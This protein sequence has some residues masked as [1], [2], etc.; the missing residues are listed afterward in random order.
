VRFLLVLLALLAGL[1]A[2]AEAP[3]SLTGDIRYQL[4]FHSQFLPNDRDIVV[5]LPPGYD[6]HPKRRYPV[7][8]M[9]DGQNLFD[10]A[11]SFI[12]GQ[13]WRADETAEALI[14]SG[15]IRPLI[16][17]GIYNGGDS[18]IDD[19]TQIADSDIKAGGKAELYG[20]LIVEELKPFI[21]SHYRTIPSETGLGGASLGGLVSLY[22]G[23]KYPDIFN[24]LA[25]L[26]PS[27]WWGKRQIL[28]D[29]AA[30][31]AK[32][33]ARIWLDVGTDESQ[34]PVKVVEDARALRDALETKGWVLGS[35][36]GYLEAE[37]EAHN[38]A[39]WSRRFD[40]VLEFLYPPNQG[41]P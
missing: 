33:P 28:R 40:R 16:I 12:P 29:V 17:V 36:F 26:S 4:G 21:D 18:R 3:S 1:S 19:Y 11:T 6:Q 13:E 32:T 41:T 31:P 10:G 14:G 39:A 23:L 20:R 5:Y 38:E 37:G 8:Y 25:V 15:K 34:T 24:E 22:L 2:Q 7:L 30:L 9:Q 27:V 35:D